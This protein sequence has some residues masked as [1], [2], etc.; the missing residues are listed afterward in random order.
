[1]PLI[2]QALIRVLGEPILQFVP[3][4]WGYALEEKVELE[5]VGSGDR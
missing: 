5:W 1:M 4:H 2:E 3:S